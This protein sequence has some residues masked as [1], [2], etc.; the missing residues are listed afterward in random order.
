MKRISGANGWARWRHAGTLAEGRTA[1]DDVVWDAESCGIRLPTLVN[2]YFQHLKGIFCPDYQ[3]SHLCTII[4]RTRQPLY[5]LIHILFN[6]LQLPSSS[7]LSSLFLPF[8]ISSFFSFF[9]FFFSISF[10]PLFFFLFSSLFFSL[11]SFTASFS[12]FPLRVASTGPLGISIPL[13]LS[14][15]TPSVSPPR[16]LRLS[17]GGEQELREFGSQSGDIPAPSA[18]LGPPLLSSAS[19]L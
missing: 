15:R 17:L 2:L 14:L 18:A 9:L 12:F 6:H 5:Q 8:P 11:F 3:D 16:C 1:G 7:L 13:V 10:I 19:P 4:S